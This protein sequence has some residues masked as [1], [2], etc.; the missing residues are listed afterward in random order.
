[1]LSIFTFTCLFKDLQK[2]IIKIPIYLFL[3][4]KEICIKKKKVITNIEV[5]D[6]N[7]CASVF[8]FHHVSVWHMF[9]VENFHFTKF[10]V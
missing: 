9:N 5:I 1:M 6:K 4:E 10:L 8:T 2:H 3:P 7:F